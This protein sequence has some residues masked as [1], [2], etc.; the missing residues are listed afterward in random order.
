MGEEEVRQRTEEPLFNGRLP[1]I[2]GLQIVDIK[3]TREHYKNAF[4]V[5]R[6][7]F[8]HFCEIR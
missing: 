1:K 7:N 4:P 8:S 5:F 2:F 3:E 6:A